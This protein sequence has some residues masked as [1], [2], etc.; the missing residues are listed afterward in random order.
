M[1]ISH[2]VKIPVIKSRD[3]TSDAMAKPVIIVKGEA[4]FQRGSDAGLLGAKFQIVASIIL[5]TR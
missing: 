4:V 5:R 1:L 2:Q 3:N